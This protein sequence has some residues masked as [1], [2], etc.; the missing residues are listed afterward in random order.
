MG[1]GEWASSPVP[2]LPDEIDLGRNE[3]P[4]EN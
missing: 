1:D 2:L 4:R 3:L